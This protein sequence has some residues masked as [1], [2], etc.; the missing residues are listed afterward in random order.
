[1]ARL[2]RLERV[3]ADLAQEV[4][5]QDNGQSRLDVVRHFVQHREDPSISAEAESLANRLSREGAPSDGRR[6]VEQIQ[7]E[8]AG[9]E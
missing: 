6:L 7:R 3:F 4:R 8:L 9:L 5:D 1:M 2:E